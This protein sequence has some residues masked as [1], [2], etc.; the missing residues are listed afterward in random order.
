[1]KRFCVRSGDYFCEVHLLK[2]THYQ[3]ALLSNYI[4]THSRALV[5]LRQTRGIRGRLVFSCRQFRVFCYIA[6]NS[7]DVFCFIVY[8]SLFSAFAVMLPGNISIHQVFSSSDCFMIVQFHIF[9]PQCGQARYSCIE[10]S[11]QPQ[12]GQCLYIQFFIFFFPLFPH[13]L[14]LSRLTPRQSY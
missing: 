2:Y 11:C 10:Y 1:M 5:L 13:I 8:R 12:A 14:L 7:N 3:R 6:I 9:S 4:A